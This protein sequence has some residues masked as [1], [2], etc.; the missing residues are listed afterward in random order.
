MNEKFPWNATH[1][2]IFTRLCQQQ[3]TR[4]EICDILQITHNTLNRCLREHYGITYRDAYNALYRGRV[5]GTYRPAQSRYTCQYN[6]ATHD[7]I[8]RV[9]DPPPAQLPTQLHPR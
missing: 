5:P 7:A 6:A 3:R 8:K 1:Q 4:D 9:M 2:A